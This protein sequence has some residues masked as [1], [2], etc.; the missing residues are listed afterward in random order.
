MAK[1]SAP[2]IEVK[3]WKRPGEAGIPEQLRKPGLRYRWA[4]DAGER[5]QK[6]VYEGWMPVDRQGKT[7]EYTGQGGQIDSFVRRKGLILMAMPE[8]MAQQR[9]AYFRDKAARQIDAIRKGTSMREEGKK[10]SKAAKAQTG[11]D[12]GRFGETIGR[13]TIS[14]NGPELEPML[15]DEKQVQE[16]LESLEA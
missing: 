6:R 8:R 4:H 10:A 1:A 3:Q 12:Y 2:K 14:K 15:A 16:D 11:K 13:V 9:D 5:F 7:V